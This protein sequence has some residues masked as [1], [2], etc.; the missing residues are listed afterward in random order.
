[1]YGLPSD[2]METFRNFPALRSNQSEH[3][4]DNGTV[5]KLVKSGYM[6][7]IFAVRWPTKLKYL[8]SFMR[9]A[10]VPIGS[11]RKLNSQVR[12]WNILEKQLY[13]I[14]GSEQQLES[15][16][17]HQSPSFLESLQFGTNWEKSLLL[18]NIIQYMQCP[19][20]VEGIDT[21]LRFEW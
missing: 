17:T 11:H 5:V 4:F 1:M 19:G 18:C 21:T 16:S 14:L 12:I 9:V 15:V 8:P 20:H 6:I 2:T 13:S 7:D 3:V 10:H